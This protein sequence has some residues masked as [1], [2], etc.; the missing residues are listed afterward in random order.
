MYI[1]I[2]V[3]ILVA[4]PVVLVLDGAYSIVKDYRKIRGGRQGPP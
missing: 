4:L 2:L 1:W 3:A